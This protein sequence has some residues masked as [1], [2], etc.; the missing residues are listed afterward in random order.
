M[1]LNLQPCSQPSHQELHHLWWNTHYQEAEQILGRKLGPVDK[2]RVRKQHPCP[3]ATL[4]AI[5]AKS[6]EEVRIF[7]NYTLFMQIFKQKMMTYLDEKYLKEIV[8]LK[9]V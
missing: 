6:M 9:V 5:P 3:Q 8:Q 1:H 2:Y 7:T 4:D